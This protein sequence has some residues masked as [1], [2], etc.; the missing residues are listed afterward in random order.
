MVAGVEVGR[1]EARGGEAGGADSTG[2]GEAP[3][4]A[5]AHRWRCRY[6]NATDGRPRARASPARRPPSS[7]C[8]Q[9]PAPVT[10]GAGCL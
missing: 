9:G 4:A 7:S 2:E 6:Y 5:A 3:V 1:G 10:A 8:C